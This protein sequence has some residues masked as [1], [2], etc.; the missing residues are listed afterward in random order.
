MLSKLILSLRWAEGGPPWPSHSAAWLPSGSR[1][2][3][4]HCGFPGG[5]LVQ[6]GPH[7]YE[8]GYTVHKVSSE[9]PL[10]A[11]SA[12]VASFMTAQGPWENSK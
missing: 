12:T 9:V 10:T 2:D 1:Q 7:A 8:E 4:M 3:E 11:M 6:P 5:A